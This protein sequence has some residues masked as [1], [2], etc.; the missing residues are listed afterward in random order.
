MPYGRTMVRAL[1]HAAFVSSLVMVLATFI[2]P[3]AALAGSPSQPVTLAQV[4]KAFGH[5]MIGVEEAG[6]WDFMTPDPTDPSNTTESR[7]F[8]AIS[9][10]IGL[11]DRPF[12]EQELHGPGGHTSFYRGYYYFHGGF[13]HD[14]IGWY[15]PQSPGQPAAFVVDFFGTHGR[16]WRFYTDIFKPLHYSLAQLESIAN[17]IR[18]EGKW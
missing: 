11:I 5:P 9:S 13:A 18:A 2:V 6:S 7:G 4:E 16:I 10:E 3:P 1:I 15:T 14:G 17:T 12:I 8:H